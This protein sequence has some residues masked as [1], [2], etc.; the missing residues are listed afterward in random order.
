MTYHKYDAS[1]WNSKESWENEMERRLIQNVKRNIE[2]YEDPIETALRS[3]IETAW[4]LTGI[5]FDD[6][7]IA[8]KLEEGGGR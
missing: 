8:A 1:Q 7:E 5:E 3:N 6:A 2:E 4:Q